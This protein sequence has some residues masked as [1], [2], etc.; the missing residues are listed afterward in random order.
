MTQP[1][2]TPDDVRRLFDEATPGPWEVSGD[3]YECNDWRIVIRHGVE[4]IGSIGNMAAT[5]DHKPTAKRWKRE[6]PANARFIAAARSGW[7]ADRERADRAEAALRQ[8]LWTAEDAPELNP[9][10]YDHD[11][12]CQLNSAMIEVWKVLSTALASQP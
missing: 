4:C 2:P 6:M 5:S 3:K 7:P 8:A 10:N 1:S 9:S 12:V 11:D